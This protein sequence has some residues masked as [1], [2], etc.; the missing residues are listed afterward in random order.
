VVRSG[1]VVAG[2]IL[3]TLARWWIEGVFPPAP[4]GFPWGTLVINV[5]GAFA[6]GVVGVV[7]LERVTRSGHLRTFLGIGLIGSYTTFSTMALEGV[8]L[9]EARRLGLAVSYWITTLVLGQMAGVYG[10]WLGRLR[11]PRWKET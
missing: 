4:P 3:G 9:I 1:S 2:G 8:Q 6:L 7:L 11:I 10:M 5:T